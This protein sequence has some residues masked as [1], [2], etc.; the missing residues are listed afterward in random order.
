MHVPSP[1]RPGWR[2]IAGCGLAAACITATSDPS[3]AARLPEH[4]A[5]RFALVD[6]TVI[7]MT[8]AGTLAHR[9][10]VIDAGR[11]AS[12]GPVDTLLPDVPVLEVPRGTVVMPGLMDLH[13][14]LLDR[15]EFLLYLANGVTTVRNLHGLGRHLA[16]RDS[17]A[18]DEILGPRLVTSGPILESP[19]LHRSTNVPVNGPAEAE[20]LVA[21]QAGAGYDYIKIYDNVPLPVYDALG[22]AAGRHGLPMLGHLPDPVGLDGLFS[23]GLQAEVEHLEELLPFTSDGRNDRLVDSLARGLARGQIAVVPTA[24]VFTSALAQSEA[25]DAHWNR[26]EMAYVNPATA[27]LWGWRETAAS[28]ADNPQAIARY[29]RTVGFFRQVLLP[30]LH[31]AGVRIIAGSDAPVPMVVPGFSLLDELE[32]Y[33]AAGLS[34]EEVL[35]TATVNAAGA[36][37]RHLAATGLG[38]ITP[39]AP[40]DLIVLSGNPLQSIGA[41]RHRLGVVARGQWW[42]SARLQRG[43]DSLAAVYRTATPR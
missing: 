22:Q 7:T 33:R 38:T 1:F 20:P 41:L 5:G 3:P 10:V 17:L 36:L 21:A 24:S 43:L 19:P 26:P 11:I 42:S 6:V 23:R 29:R 8:T 9:T 16:W 13:V 27:S 30:R 14:H 34:P 2:S 35:R 12:V 25:P 37:P 31:R 40:A 32:F 15:D 39:G 18:R 28:R 4:L